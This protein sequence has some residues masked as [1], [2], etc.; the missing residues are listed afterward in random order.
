M[1]RPA[2]ARRPHGHRAHSGRS[3][4]HRK[5]GN[6]R[7]VH[8]SAQPVILPGDAIGVLCARRDM[9]MPEDFEEHHNLC[10]S[11]CGS[12]VKDSFSLSLLT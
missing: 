5:C 4:S 9:L 6:Y 8:D 1:K 11:I 10:D 7:F 2:K 12:L 3:G